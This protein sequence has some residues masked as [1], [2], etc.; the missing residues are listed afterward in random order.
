M[1]REAIVLLSGGLDSAT[2]LAIAKSQGFACRAIT[3]DYMQR[4]RCEI[5][6]AQRVAS[7]LGVLEHLVF[8]MDFREIGGSALTSPVPVPIGRALDDMREIPTTYVPGRNSIFLAIAAGLAEAR[9]ARDL[10]LGVNAIDYSGYPDCRPEFVGAME[11]AVARGTKCGV[12]GDRIR[13]HAPLIAMTKAQVI[14]TGH[15]LMVNYSLT[16]SCYDPNA[17]GAACG[18]CDSCLIRR[19]GFQVAGITDPT[20]YAPC[21]YPE[22]T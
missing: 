15:D 8:R 4:H 17:Q 12:E 1:P 21:T 19:A 3:F 18:R 16:H 7:S 5:E 22:K 6:A 2:V 10:F 9:G 14:Q 11:D 20:Q 13:F